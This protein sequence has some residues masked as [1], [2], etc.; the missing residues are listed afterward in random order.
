MGALRYI[1]VSQNT[2]LQ[3][4]HPGHDC[5]T[6][7]KTLETI[8]FSNGELI[9][10]ATN[11]VP[12]CIQFKNVYLRNNKLVDLMDVLNHIY[13]KSVRHLDLSENLISFISVRQYFS[14]YM[15]TFLQMTEIIIKFKIFSG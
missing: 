15:I 9:W 11:F 7:N 2:R 8:D 12:N 1:N 4:V 13:L 10:L 3:L 14:K 6:S 5:S